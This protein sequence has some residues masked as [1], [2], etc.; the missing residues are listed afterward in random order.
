M[1]TTESAFIKHVPCPKCGS[2]D[3]AGQYSDGH[4]YCFGCGAWWTDG[5]EI[6]QEE[7][8]YIKMEEIVEGKVRAI[9]DRCITEETCKK[10][11]VRTLVKDHKIA[12]H[13]YPYF[14]KAG[15]KIAEKVRLCA[16]KEFFWRGNNSEIQLF[17]AQCQ[18][19]TGR[20]V[21][22]T[23][24][25][26]DCMSLWQTLGGRYTVVSLPNG[27]KNFKALK[28]NYQYLDQFENI[29]LCLDGDKAGREAVERAVQYL[30]QKKLKIMR[31][32]DDCKDPNEFLKKGKTQE[33]MNYFW[34]AEEYRPVD[35]VNIGDL[36]ERLA[37][38]RKTHEYIPTPWIGLNDMIQGTRPGQLVVLAAGC[39]SA[40][41]EFFTGTGWKR[42]ADYQEGDMVMQY[43]PA[44]MEA[45]MVSPEA[46]IKR[47]CEWLY[48][49]K[50]KYGLDMELSPEHNVLCVPE[51]SLEHYKIS[52]EEVAKK[53]SKFRGRIPTAFS[54]GGAGI[55]LTDT[56]IKLMLAVIADGSID[57]K[58]IRFHIKKQRKKDELLKILKEYGRPYI[59][60]D[61]KDGY[62]EVFLVPPRLEKEF[63]SFWYGCDKRQ[64]Q[65]IC[66]NILQWDGHVE[67]NRSSFSA[68]VKANAEFVQF[69]FSACGYKARLCYEDRRGQMRGGYVRK[70]IDWIVHI[71]KRSF[72]GM[73]G[74]SGPEI[75]P[76]TDG[77]KYCFTVPTHCLVLRLNGCVFCTGNT[78]MGKSA[79]LKSW[80][81]HLVRTTDLHIG[82]LY[83]EENPEETVLSLMSMAAGKNMKKNLVWDSTSEEDKRKY[84]DE[85]GA[86]RR[87][88]LFEP[89]SS[90]DP[91]Y[92]CNK[93]RYMVVV[94]DCKYI[95]LDHITYITE[96]EDDSHGSLNKL[97]KTLHSLCVELGIV[98][99]AACHLRKSANAQKTAEE[100]GRIT[101]DDMKNSSSIKQLSDICIGLER[102]SQA[103]DPVK[104]NTTVMRVL[105]SRDFGVKGPC[106]ALFYDKDTTRLQEVGLE[107]EEAPLDELL[108]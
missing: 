40:D 45:T 11:G 58:R 103:D 28:E 96:A 52:A 18:P 8:R 13:F 106:T 12:K 89:L 107:T 21:V 90:T 83:L 14:N 100:G 91:E 87:I 92:I 85:C 102:N 10:F 61:K 105:K 16:T 17:G 86:N 6:V 98:I 53:G 65:L 19:T 23:E 44:T 22:V 108:K 62:A 32:P 15:E 59:W 26:V 42:I 95:V 2:R 74:Y 20:F 30:P 51:E 104:A 50:T 66:D 75:V 37:E 54:Y 46:Y 69:A 70:S 55:P 47:P 24:G 82:A 73:R 9:A 33:L 77:Y 93:I 56:E 79:F 57:H 81:Y 76:T 39:V 101:L 94:R 25:C 38:Y 7:R 4:Y 99:L 31:L 71:T 68:N 35:I 72:V 48:K 84:F 80:M 49:F 29:V 5:K 1:E 43:D 67:D 41:T 60:N 34:R 88:E 78:G 63:G 27:C 97:M 36:Y 64:L 3:N